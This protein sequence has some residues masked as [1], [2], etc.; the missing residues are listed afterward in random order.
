MQIV[1][2]VYSDSQ[3]VNDSICILK[4]RIK[5]EELKNDFDSLAEKVREK[6]NEREFENPKAMRLWE[7]AKKADFS[8]EELDSI[9]Q[10][11]H[12]FEHRWDWLVTRSSIESSSGS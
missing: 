2:T 4:I 3:W 9:R 10:E 6:L 1:S 5:H 8:K 11:L 7:L 12:H